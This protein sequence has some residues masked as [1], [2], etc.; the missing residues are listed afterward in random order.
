MLISLQ[1]A[2][3]EM[4]LRGEP[5]EKT[6]ELLCLEAEKLAPDAICSVLTVDAAGRLHPLASPSLPDHF[7]ASIDGLAIGPM[8]GSC[9]SAAYL[10]E[11]VGVEDIATDPRWQDCR[12]LA[13]PLGLCACWSSPIRAQTSGEVVGTFAFYYRTCRGPSPVE[14]EIVE[15]CVDLCAL[16]IERDRVQAEK[17]RLAYYD[18]LTG[19]S[20]R[21]SF[22]SVLDEALAAHPT[23]LALLLI[24]IDRLKS[25]NDTFGH[26]AGDGYIR[27]I[28]ARIAAEA[29][30]LRCFRLGGDEFAIIVAGGGSAVGLASL[31]T[32]LLGAMSEPIECDGHMILPAITI[33]GAL[34]DPYS[35]S[36]QSLRQNADFALY[37]AKE[38]CRGRFVLYAPGLRTTMSQRAEVVRDVAD[39]LDEGR[40]EV[41]YQPVVRLDTREI[42]GVEALCRM[43]TSEHTLVPARDFQEAMEDASVACRLTD[44]ILSEVAGHVRAWLDLGL[45][46]QHVGIN[47]TTADFRRGQLQE[48]ILEAFERFGVSLKHVVLEVTETVYIGDGDD[49]TVAKAVEALRAEG[50]LVAL[51]DFG[52]GYASL[53]HLLSF[54]V[55]IIKIDRSFV[56]RLAPGNE[57]SI[58]TAGL[59]DICRK[60]GVRVVAEGVETEE[61]AEQLQQFGCRLG[62]G[63][64]FA[65]PADFSVTTERMRRFAQKVRSQPDDAPP[66]NLTAA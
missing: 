21:A 6:A 2:I 54:P 38:T 9:G 43:R 39:A 44:R 41:H 53:T 33:G 17:H 26:A 34:L 51:D 20:N 8:V 15:T 64:L 65:R 28:A 60:L 1:N 63:F 36:Q 13:L 31:A 46:F 24:D 7:S 58:I 10:G 56:E 50:L 11:P 16:A 47:V 29:A 57:S 62:Q 61:Q 19:L 4:I 5:L 27:G 40:I 23:D 55:D 52:T 45:P 3:F 30:P 66:R 35:D 18:T 48:R 25:V 22:Q 42:I 59:I 32:R 49:R 12:S 37:H 14:R